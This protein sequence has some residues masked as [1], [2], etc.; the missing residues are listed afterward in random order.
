MLR[1]ETTRSCNPGPMHHETG[2]S[3]DINYLF[4]TPNQVGSDEVPYN[5]INFFSTPLL[6]YPECRFS[7]PNNIRL[8]TVLKDFKPDVIHLM[9]EF[10]LGFAGLQYAKKYGI[11]VISNYSTNFDMIFSQYH[12][13]ILSKPLN[14]YLSW[15]HSEANLTVTP[16]RDSK[17]VLNDMGVNNVEL[18][19]R[20][21]DTSKFSP[22]LRDDALR[23]EM[24]ITNRIAMLYVGRVSA[25]KDLHLLVSVME[26]LNKLYKERITLIIAGD[27]PMKAELEHKLP[28]S[29]I[30]LPLLKL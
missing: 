16:S 21:I 13:D 26:N 28:R 19:Q 18:F 20:G 23:R 5:C 9:T 27:G 11:P 1:L 8:N 7:I 30:H 14:K 15:F 3:Y 10:N 6:F 25:K 2:G 22:A 17:N 4:I 24:G 12:L 29:M